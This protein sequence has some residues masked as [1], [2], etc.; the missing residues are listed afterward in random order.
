MR[1][2]IPLTAALLEKLLV[3]HVLLDPHLPKVQVSAIA[4]L[5]ISVPRDLHPAINVLPIQ[6]RLDPDRQSVSLALSSTSIAAESMST[7]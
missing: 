6:R 1:I 7:A 4:A 5:V 2:I 3:K